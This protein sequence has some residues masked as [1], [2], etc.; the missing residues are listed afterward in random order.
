MPDSIT[1]MGNYSFS[2]CSSLLNIKIPTGVTIL[3]ERLFERCSSLTTL[4]IPDNV[5]TILSYLCLDC[6]SLVSVYMSDN[7]TTI[8]QRCFEYCKSLRHIYL[9]NGITD[10]SA[11][12]NLLNY[13]AVE[14]LELP[15]NI[16][17]IPQVFFGRSNIKTLVI[18]RKVTT[19]GAS[20]FTGCSSLDKITLPASVTTINAGAFTNV[21]PTYIDSSMSKIE[22]F[23]GVSKLQTLIL[24]Y[25]GVV[26]DL[27][28]Y[29]AKDEDS[30]PVPATLEL[31]G[32]N[33]VA[34]NS[35]VMPMTNLDTYI[36]TPNNWLKIYVPANRLTN[37]RNTYPKLVDY[38][39][40]IT[41]DAAVGNADRVNGFNVGTDGNLY[42]VEETH[43]TQGD[44]RCI[45]ISIGNTTL[46][47]DISLFEKGQG[48]NTWY[49]LTFC[50]TY[51]K[52]AIALTIAN[53]NNYS[54]VEEFVF[55][56]GS[57]YLKLA[58]ISNTYTY[59]GIDNRIKY[60][61]EEQIP[62]NLNWIKYR[63]NATKDKVVKYEFGFDDRRNLNATTFN[64][65]PAADYALKT[66]LS[67]VIG[68]DASDDVFDDYKSTTIEKVSVADNSATINA[69]TGTYYTVTD[70]VDNLNITLPDI[71]DK[72]HIKGIS[73][74]F[75]TGSTPAVS[76]SS[77]ADI[78]YFSGYLIEADTTYELNFMFN[79][80][81]WIV[82]YGV[83]E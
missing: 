26:K 44:E 82:A 48:G 61:T 7:V 58:Y 43:T 36:G 60:I 22:N 50:N 71:A 6:T 40:P 77:K 34:I 10:L 78:A 81:K 21:T 80:E 64:G 32:D 63:N 55:Y 68:E 65:L 15:D 1:S 72:E 57:L 28:T 18:P 56:D 74:M 25:N 3:S 29:V 31:N 24:R 53:T 73:V 9:S 30:I 79:G 59:Y 67:N 2:Y 14:E 54:A 42:K 11:S 37:Y 38:L 62:E 69:K 76:I 83:I 35:E 75:T 12:H 8:G 41:G 23:P 52:H 5:T 27:D 16:E 4:T 49:Y 51:N 47:Q 39:Y 20:A 45:V 70:V 19:I 33:A 66:D 13:S 46:K 17:T